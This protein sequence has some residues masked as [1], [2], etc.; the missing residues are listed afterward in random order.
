[1]PTRATTADR[2]HLRRRAGFSWRRWKVVLL[3]SDSGFTEILVG[4]FLLGLRG[5]ILLDTGFAYTSVA[6]LMKGVGITADHMGLV[7]IT[8]GLSQVIAAGTGY[9]R[10]R[11]LIA[12]LAAGACMMVWLAYFWSDLNDTSNAWTWAGIML[13]EA[14]LCWRVLLR[15]A[16]LLGDDNH[17][18]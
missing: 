16:V 5:L 17:D 15:R 9:F 2:P 7:F 3:T 4:L 8:C 11:A 13:S 18:A 12:F 1:M 10:L 6:L 14:V